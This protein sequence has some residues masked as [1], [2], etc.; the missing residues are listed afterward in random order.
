MLRKSTRTITILY[1]HGA[2]LQNNTFITMSDSESS[3]GIRG[4]NTL[5]ADGNK[6]RCLIERPV[7]VSTPIGAQGK[8]P[9]KLHR[10]TP[11]QVSIRIQSC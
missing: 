7:N 1:T 2:V 9:R 4:I 6:L 3:Q 8:R 11:K 10:G 5:K